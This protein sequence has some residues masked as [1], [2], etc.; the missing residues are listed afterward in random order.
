MSM[1]GC[2]ITSHCQQD[3]L[4]KTEDN[5]KKAVFSQICIAISDFLLLDIAKKV[6]H[7]G[8]NLYMMSATN[9]K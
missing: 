1:S 2:S 9:G 5:M 7:V 4:T 6:Y 8:K 3:F